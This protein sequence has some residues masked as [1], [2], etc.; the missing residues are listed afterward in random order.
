MIYP[1]PSVCA[2]CKLILVH[3]KQ[4]HLWHKDTEGFWYARTKEGPKAPTQK[5]G[6]YKAAGFLGRASLRQPFL[7]WYHTCTTAVVLCILKSGLNIFWVKRPREL[8]SEIIKEIFRKSA[9]APVWWYVHNQA[10]STRCP[11]FA[12]N[13]SHGSPQPPQPLC[14]CSSLCSDQKSQKQNANILGIFGCR[15]ISYLEIVACMIWSIR[16]RVCL[17]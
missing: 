8:D 14:T 3:Q 7:L 12:S 16:K 1:K 5:S 4:F 2:L 11:G 15:W 17:D 13:A 9:W 6:H 10:L